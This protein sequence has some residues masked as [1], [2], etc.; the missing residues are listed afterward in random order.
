MVRKFNKMDAQ[1]GEFPKK[2]RFHSHHQI[3]HDFVSN[4]DQGKAIICFQGYYLL[5]VN[6]IYMTRDWKGVFH[7]I[8]DLTK[9]DA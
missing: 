5:D 8:K 1:M 7:L 3:S 2:Q 6:H 9:M 4:P